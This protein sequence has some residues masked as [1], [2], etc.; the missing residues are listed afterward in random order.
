MS[1]SDGTFD[2]FLDDY[3][4]E[5]D[6]HVTNVRRVLLELEAAL[7]QPAGERVAIAELFRFFH[8]VKGISAMVELRPAEELAH[9]LE[10]YLR[11]VRNRELAV[12]SEG[13]EVLI[14]G[15]RR[16]EGIIHARKTHGP[17]PD[18]DDIVARVT[19]LV[20]AS[21]PHPVLGPE[22]E[23]DRP[24]AASSSRRWTCT[25]SPTRE[26]LARG[27]GVDAV[28]KQLSRIGTI[29]E[30]APLVRPD[31]TIAFQFTLATAEGAGALALL[32]ADGVIVE[33][34][35]QASE[36]DESSMS[37]MAGLDAPPEYGPAASTTQSVAPSHVVRV[38][39]DRLDE[40]MTNVGDLVISRARLTDSL[41][42][43]EQYVPAVEWRAI[44]DNAN[45]IDR[46]LRTLRERIMRVRLVPIGEIFRRMPFVVR[47]LARETGK[48]VRIEL[49]GQTTEIDKYLIERMMDPVLHLVRNA[50]SHGIETVEER[51]AAGKPPDGTIILSASAAGAVVT[52]EVA[53]DGRGVDSAAV[54]ARARAAGVPVVSDS[55]DPATLL[56]L[57]CAP[58]FST[59][60][61]AD[62]VSGRGVGMAVVKTTVEELSGTIELESQA[63]AGTR[64]VLQLPLTL[65]ITDALIGRVGAES[66]AVPQSAVREVVAVAADDVRTVEENEIV[67][68]RGGALTI[69]RLGRLFGIE[70]RATGRFHLFVIGTG[71]AAVGL[72]VDRIVGHREIVVRAIADP[73]AKV[74]G[75]AGAT[76]LGDGRVVL[77]LDPATLS[78]LTR[79]RA[80][81]ALGNAAEWG[82]MRA[83]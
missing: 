26:L 75:I 57:I 18:F 73:L 50:V 12:S 43:V 37:P 22:P 48:R 7:G 46:Q 20:A 38:D 55:P 64:F 32:R 11:A 60:T 78:R 44:H 36:T 2:G 28:R 52:L 34:D 33:P 53:D 66:F 16:L 5:C 56:S 31:G 15:T 27:V 41:A 19:R 81:R 71:L 79:Q 65:A 67:P 4:A 69:V 1:P 17:S 74:D 51:L 49:K 10:H 62:R 72:A 83:R 42:R 76:D 45:V 61:D 24:P 13:I 59:K 40:L 25:F 9:H 30:A 63:G 29:L 23:D 54:V 6:E 58:G 8:S 14:D 68:Y 35:G 39:L 70:S 82:R 77:I 3:F 47:D 21:A 80:A